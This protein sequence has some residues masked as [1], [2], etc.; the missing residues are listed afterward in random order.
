MN[1]QMS[2][3]LPPYMYI[4]G[5]PTI[6]Y[7]STTKVLVLS[8]RQQQML[9]VIMKHFEINLSDLKKRKK[10]KEL[11]YHRAICS[12]LLYMHGEL[13]LKS[14]GAIYSQHHTTILNQI[15][16]VTDQLS[17]KGENPYK[18][19]ISS[20]ENIIYSRKSIVA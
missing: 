19:D 8:E 9:D 18:I 15:Q 13:T 2:H 6:K 4:P 3:K 11:V 14:I 16:T 10:C 1:K 7:M 12:Y 5:I 17:L 20:L